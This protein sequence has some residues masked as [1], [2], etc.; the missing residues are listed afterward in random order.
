MVKLVKGYVAVAN[1]LMASQKIRYIKNGSISAVDRENGVVVFRAAG[2][3]LKSINID[4]TMVVSI[5][6]GETLEG[7]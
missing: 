2:I 5:S 3:G 6:T 4:K 7:E 1:K